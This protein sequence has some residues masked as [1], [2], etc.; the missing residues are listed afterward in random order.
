MANWYIDH[1]C[2]LYPTAY[3]SAPSG[4]GSFPQEGDGKASGTGSTPA[5]SSASMDFTS[6]TAAAGA[7]FAV[8]GATLTCVASG[9][10][11]N[12]FNAGSGSTLASNLASA[13]NAATASPT[14]TTGGISSPYL[15]ALVWATTSGATL[16]VYSRVAS[17]DLNQS[18]NASCTLVCGSLGNW[19]SA[20]S[21]SNFTGGVSGPWSIFFNSSALTAAVNASISG[22]GTYGGITA[23]MMG[24]P[25]AGDIINVRT[26]RS[27]ANISM[28]GIGGTAFAVTTRSVGTIGAYLEYRFDNGVVWNDGN[29]N[30]VFTLVKDSTGQTPSITLVGY[31]WWHGQ[32]QSG[33]DVISGGQVNFKINHTATDSTGY[34][35]NFTAGT[36]YGVRH[37]V[38][39]GIEVADTGAG[40]YSASIIWL[41]QPSLASDPHRPILYR[42]CKIG[43]ARSGASA[44][45]GTSSYGTMVLAEDC[46]FAYGGATQYTAAIIDS[47]PTTAVNIK[48]VRPKFTGGGGGH[49]ILMP[50]SA[51]AY[52]GHVLQIEDPVDMG[53][54]IAS[55]SAASY[56]G[57][58]S[59]ASGSG[60]APGADLGHGQ[61]IS[62]S[63]NE[64]AFL[65][66]TP[67]RLIE[68]RSASF[69]TTG[70]S[71]LLDG[72]NFSFRFSVPHTGFASGLVNA[73]YPVRAIK[74]VN[75]NTLGDSASLTVTERILI[76][77]SYGGS[78]YTP[79]DAE[80]WIE[81]TY[82]SS[83]DSSVKRFTTKGTGSNLS[84][85]TQTWS[86]LTYS[87]F[88]GG[89]RNY[90]RWKIAA[91]LTNVKGNTEISLFLVCAKQPST[92]NEWCFIDPMFGMA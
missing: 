41:V 15:K 20:P 36:N 34:N 9:A 90:S 18:T 83:T 79:T 21:A 48:L 74:Q 88:S 82:V 33:S 56:C 57:R 84:S 69:P 31:T 24:A 1:G 66:D 6:A 7:T 61:F 8:H 46:L 49:H 60:P 27:S 12:Q 65:I 76:D 62:S 70:L 68:W 53:Q 19:T 71:Q 2:T 47:G 51:T 29:S 73:G 81:G 87:P 35:F 4:A 3:M 22:A 28:T 42:N 75:T 63:N 80:W 45:R 26:G 85:D 5:V 64:R 72:T 43:V 44:F 37:S 67:R 55:D 32:M 14:V 59:G 17:A 50:V 91:T 25:A 10:T 11:T 89:S 54:F 86:S 13:I 58:I 30:G 23:T 52:Y 77:S 16:T 92:M 38:V 78:S 39:E 40:S